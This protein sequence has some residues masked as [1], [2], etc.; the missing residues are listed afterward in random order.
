M[1]SMHQTHPH[2][3]RLVDR[4]CIKKTVHIKHVFF[5]RLWSPRSL[6]RDI[7]LE[8][9]DNSVTLKCCLGMVLFSPH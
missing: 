1:P 4:L 7:S 5:S 9:E 3:M 6:A 2:V 8:M